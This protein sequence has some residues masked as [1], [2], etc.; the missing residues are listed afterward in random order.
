MLVA[1]EERRWRRTTETIIAG[2]EA[3]ILNRT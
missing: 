3:E 1:E 2:E